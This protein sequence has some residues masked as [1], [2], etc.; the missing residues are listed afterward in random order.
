MKLKRTAQLNFIFAIIGIFYIFGSFFLI[1]VSWKRGIENTEERALSLVK[2]AAIGINGE[3]AKLLKGIPSDQGTPPYMSIKNRLDEYPKNKR[4][5]QF[6]Y[7]YTMRNEKV[8]FM[9]DSEPIGSEDY[10]PPGQEYIGA[11]EY[12]K[13]PFSS[14]QALITPPYSDDWGTWVSALAPLVNEETGEVYAVLGMDYPANTWELEAMHETGQSVIISIAILL[15]ILTFYLILKSKH[16]LKI[17][18]EDLKNSLDQFKAIVS[19]APGVIYRCLPDTNW[20]MQFISQDIE[21]I[22]GF[23]SDEFIQNNTRTYES[24]IYKD[25][26]KMVADEIYKAI[27]K[28]ES[29]DIE[30][31]IVHKDFRLRW[32]KEKGQAVYDENGKPK[33]LDGVIVDITDKKEEERKLIESEA[34]VKTIIQGIGDGVFAVDKNLK[35]TLFNP[36]ASRLSGYSEEEALGKPYKEILNFTYEKTGEINDTFVRKA[37]ETGEIQEMANHTLLHKKDGTSISVS[38]N[39]APLK[40]SAGNIFGCV[41]VFRDVTREREIDRSKT[42]FVSVA[43]HQL[44]T[45]LSGI[46]W[47]SEMLLGDK[48]VKPKEKQIEYLKD[49]HESNERLLKLVEEL[50]DVSHIETGRKFEIRKEPTNIVGVV[51]EILSENQILA[52]EKGVKIIKCAGSPDE[53]ILNIDGEKIRQVFGNLINNAIKY[54]KS[55]GLVEIG[56]KEESE[57]K[58]F[59]VRDHGI[60][61]PKEQQEKVY[62]KFFRADNAL[63]KE[64]DGTGLGLY[65]AKTIIESHGGEIWFESVEGEGTTFYF[66]I[67]LEEGE[68]ITSILG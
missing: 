62:E 46:K 63:T 57:K 25:D 29:W 35:I 30:Y 51:G 24:I 49:I 10:S 50:L 15:L 55:G 61:I 2:I 43:S 31:R 8:Y 64:T 13:K 68:N 42:E 48:I 65:I 19:N 45:P 22:C 47:L 27:E 28:Q 60:G 44:K 12:H 11:N 32:V 40:D 41:V 59:F 7:L 18:K 54:S 26:A 67:P 38:D 21:K 53:L 33:F 58:V 66:S 56:C 39:A 1:K 34:R 37:F 36:M 6:A 3:M 52:E 16:K 23:P 4:N 20:T 9:V 14:K 5:V 17:T